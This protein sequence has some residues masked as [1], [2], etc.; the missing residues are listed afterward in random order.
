[1]HIQFFA[2]VWFT[3]VFLCVLDCNAIKELNRNSILPLWE[4]VELDELVWKY[5][6][7]RNFSASNS[8]LPIDLPTSFEVGN[9][10]NDFMNLCCRNVS[11]DTELTSHLKRMASNPI[12]RELDI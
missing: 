4:K 1:M 10:V 7:V 12:G 8:E 5:E 2:P 9:L 11:S 6:H 3:L